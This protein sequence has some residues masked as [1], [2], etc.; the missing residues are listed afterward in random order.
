MTD[1]QFTILVVDDTPQNLR[2]LLKILSDQNYDVR[3]ANG[4]KAAFV[5]VNAELPDLILLDIMMPEIDGYEVCRQLKAVERTRD[6]PVIFISALDD[7]TNK[8]NGFEVGGVDYITKP[9]QAEEVL[10]RV[11]THLKL[12]FMQ[13]SLQQRNQELALLHRVGQLFNST[14]EFDQVLQTV[15]EEINN[16]INVTATSFWLKESASSGELV[17]RQA[18]GVWREQVIGWRLLVGQGVAGWVVEHRQSFVMADKANVPQYYSGVAQAIDLDVHSILSM[19]LWVKGEVIGALNLV[20][21]KP[22]RFSENDL[23]S[24]EPLAITAASAVEN[25]RLYSLMRQELTERKQAEAEL[26]ALFSAMTDVVLMINQEGRYLK[27]APTSPD[28]LYKP[29]D[30]LLG[31]TLHE[32][33]PKPQADLFLSKIQQSLASKQM[34]SLEYSLPICGLEVWFE[35]RF[36]PIT[37]EEVVIVAQDITER[38]HNEDMLRHVNEI[39]EERIVQRTAELAQSETKYHSIFENSNDV[40]FVTLADGHVADINS[41]CG[42]FGYTKE[43]MIGQRAVDFYINPTDYERYRQIVYQQGYVRNFETQLKGKDGR[44]VDVMITATANLAKD[45]TITGF[46]GIIRDVTAQKQA[47][48]ERLQMV[49]IQQELNLAQNIQQNLLPPSKPNYAD[50]DMVCFSKPAQQVGGDFYIYHQV[51]AESKQ[52]FLR[53][54]QQCFVIAVGDVSGKGLSAALLMSVSLVAFKSV[55]NQAYLL[56]KSVMGIAGNNS[57]GDLLCTLDEMIANYV[58]SSRQNCALVCVELMM[59]FTATEPA[60]IS[61]VNAGCI[62]PYIKRVN[63]EVE[64]PE[65]CGFALGQGLGAKAGYQQLILKIDKG[66]TIILVSDGVVEANN[67]NGDMLGFERLEQIIKNIVTASAEEMLDQLKQAIFGFTGEAEQND[68]ITIIV[69]RM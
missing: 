55:V 40:I 54:D 9:F 8:V 7:V 37:A 12:Y 5:A 53:T 63:G 10:T 1:K 30:E 3:L 58:G 64:N 6:I 4:G 20:S 57:L 17:C 38:K 13:R 47:E 28:L 50:L 43:E 25:A 68:D 27:I 31:K 51:D 49:A 22:G 52:K 61:V 15:L 21:D 29:A 36:S 23:A 69:A 32:V 42:M 14:L 65:I 2:L 19:P 67:L 16:L 44:S 11:K 41:A 24:L 59:P 34:V 39:L 45:G 56:S 60:T 35:G 66:D 26:Q 33:F 62:P 46:Q 18:T 48:Q